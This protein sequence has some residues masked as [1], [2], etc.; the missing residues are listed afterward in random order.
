MPVLSSFLYEADLSLVY[1]LEIFQ[2][3][4]LLLTY[5]H[6]KKKEGN[7]K[8]KKICKITSIMQKVKKKEMLEIVFL[9]GGACSPS[10]GNLVTLNRR[11]T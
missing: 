5:S 4:E 6:V 2:T 11:I 9:S 7:A 1:V 3:L 8:K 10:D